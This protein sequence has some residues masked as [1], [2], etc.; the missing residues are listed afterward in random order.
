[1]ASSSRSRV[2]IPDAYILFGNIL[3][4]IFYLPHFTR[5][6]CKEIIIFAFHE[7]YNIEL[8]YLWKITVLKFQN[9]CPIKYISI[10]YNSTTLCSN[11]MQCGTYKY[12]IIYIKILLPKRYLK[13]RESFVV[14]KYVIV[15]N[16]YFFF[17]N[18]ERAKR[19]GDTQA[20]H[21]NIQIDM[22]QVS[23]MTKRPEN[24]RRMDIIFV[25]Q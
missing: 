25:A 13:L 8:I 7:N 21:R 6:D 10:K 22:E 17:F 16:Y 1:M 2:R 15:D 12:F 18:L 20:I 9:V 5:R 14:I 23:E 19:F 11:D 24:S 3:C 4:G